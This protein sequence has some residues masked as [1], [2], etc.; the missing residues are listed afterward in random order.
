MNWGLEE[1]STLL[2][3]GVNVTGNVCSKASPEEKHVCK[4]QACF[5]QNRTSCQYCPKK[6]SFQLRYSYGYALNNN[7]RILVVTLQWRHI[8]MQELEKGVA[9]GEPKVHRLILILRTVASLKAVLPFNVVN[10]S[11]QKPF[12]LRTHFTRPY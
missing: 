11:D 5:N 1:L 3:T 10:T 8:L 9:P 4:S 7:K 6:P 2:S 12:T